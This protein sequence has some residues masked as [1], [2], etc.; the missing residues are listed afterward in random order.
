MLEFAFRLED[1][2]ARAV[3]KYNHGTRPEKKNKSSG[4]PSVL[5][6]AILPNISV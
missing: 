6:L 4:I 2:D 1:E 5:K 3:V